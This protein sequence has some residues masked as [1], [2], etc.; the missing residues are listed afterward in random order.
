MIQPVS[1]RA[2]T[3]YSLSAKTVLY[4]SLIVSGLGCV[5]TKK[6]A[7]FQQQ[8]ASD[9][10]VFVP[11]QY[12]P[13]IKAGD[14]LS[15]Q[16][17]SLS[18]EA[19]AFF[20][21]FSKMPE[22]ANQTPAVNTLP[23]MSGYLVDVAGN[24][25]FPILGKI[26]VAGQTTNELRDK[27]RERLSA[28]LKEPTIQIRNLNF[29]VSVLGEVTRPSLFTIPNEQIT[30]TEAL[31]L[32]GDITIYGR[33]DNVLIIREENGQRNFA[34]VDLTSRDV[35]RSPYYNLHVNDIVYVEPGKARATS[36]DRFYQT[37]PLVLSA[38]SVIAI[39]LTRS[40]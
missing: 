29:R 27:M 20:N 12:I 5:S 4:L 2:S 16:V 3:L 8:T 37:M 7:L 19:A 21:P 13:A 34:R 33:R 17:G 22:T 40:R 36:A 35:F 39:V 25:E 11:R 28:Y 1:K 23:Y 15:I 24:I 6:L 10:T 38:L 14:V 31:G 30:L 26:S 9:K 18:G 32:A